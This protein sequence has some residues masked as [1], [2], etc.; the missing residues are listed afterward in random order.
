M[1]FDGPSK[2]EKA[3]NVL[4]NNGPFN[5][6]ELFTYRYIIISVKKIKMALRN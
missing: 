5:C 2:T 4:Y 6:V 3:D 1:C